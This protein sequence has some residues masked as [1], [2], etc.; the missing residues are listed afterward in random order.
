MLLLRLLLLLMLVAN[1]G[2]EPI[3]YSRLWFDIAN[4]SGG[5][6]DY[7]DRSNRHLESTAATAAGK[8]IG[9]EVRKLPRFGSKN[10]RH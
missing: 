7:A 9:G 3:A 2:A 4:I 6:P 10:I 5:A 1:D 8:V